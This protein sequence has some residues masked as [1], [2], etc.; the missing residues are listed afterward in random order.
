MVPTDRDRRPDHL[1]STDNA[2][3]DHLDTKTDHQPTET[4]TARSPSRCHRSA[5]SLR[6]VASKRHPQPTD[7]GDTSDKKDRATIY[8]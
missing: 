4:P 1:A 5:K 3:P 2:D 6:S 8:C 7:R